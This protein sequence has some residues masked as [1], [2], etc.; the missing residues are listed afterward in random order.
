MS[1]LFGTL[2][3]DSFFLP[4]LKLEEGLKKVKINNFFLAISNNIN[5]YL[6]HSDKDT[7]QAFVGIPVLEIK[8]KN[9]FYKALT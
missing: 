4:E 7:V 9:K 5:S 3:K 1:W 6:E 8:V 2:Q